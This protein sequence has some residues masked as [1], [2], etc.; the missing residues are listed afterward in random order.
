MYSSLYMAKGAR[1]RKGWVKLLVS[2]DT[3]DREDTG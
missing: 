2:Q 3:E 1:G